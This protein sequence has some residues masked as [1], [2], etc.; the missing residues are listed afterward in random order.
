MGPMAPTGVSPKARQCSERSLVPS[1]RSQLPEE[2]VK[3]EAFSHA[4]QN[5]AERAPEV[6]GAAHESVSKQPSMV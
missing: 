5:S 1:G 4:W 6:S 3:V 2:G